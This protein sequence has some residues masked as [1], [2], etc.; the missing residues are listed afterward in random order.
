MVPHP[1]GRPRRQLIDS[2]PAVCRPPALVLND[3]GRG[4]VK[5][6][7]PDK[8][9]RRQVGIGKR[10]QTMMRMMSGGVVAVALMT[11]IP[12]SADAQ[13]GAR[14]QGDEDLHSAAPHVREA[15]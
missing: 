13:R 5:K 15:Q 3:P 11:L 2:L 9:T 14:G 10:R 12:A 4:D 8:E 7:E 1:E 6:S